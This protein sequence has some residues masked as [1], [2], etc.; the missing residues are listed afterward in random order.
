MAR[1]YFDV[2]DKSQVIRDDVGTEFDS[3]DEAIHGAT[4]SAAEIGTDRLGKGIFSDVVVEVR[5]ERDQP[6]LTVTAS[7]R[8]ERHDLPSHQPAQVPEPD[9]HRA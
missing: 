2:H 1:Y 9:G 4:R 3:L 5:D 6:I 8:I 7:M